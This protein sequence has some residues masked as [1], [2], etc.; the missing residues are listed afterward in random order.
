MAQSQ[1]PKKEKAPVS[2]DSIIKK[3]ISQRDAANKGLEKILNK[4]KENTKNQS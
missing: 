4:M 1:K 2:E 3:L